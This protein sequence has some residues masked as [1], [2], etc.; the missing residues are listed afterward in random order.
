M[1]FE[2]LKSVIGTLEQQPSW[3]TRRQFY[4][5]VQ[6]WPKAVGHL[7]ARQTRPV[8][9]QRQV[10]YV[11]VS[12]A[13]WAQTLTFERQHILAQLNGRLSCPL[14]DLKFSAAQWRQSPAPGRRQP[15][16]EWLR[17]HPSYVRPTAP[18]QTEATKAEAAKAE[19][20]PTTP[21]RSKPLSR[22]PAPRPQ[23]SESPSLQP[24]SLQ[25]PSLQSP[26]SEPLTKTQQAF[27]KWSQQIRASHAHQVLCPDCHCHCPKGEIARWQK[28][29]LCA[30]K[31]WPIRQ[32]FG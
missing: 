19:P 6:Y 29:A 31:Q 9:I 2:P 17:Q 21:S 32:P 18:A 30:A 27:E 23:T 3:Q 20:S 25:S 12:T 8:S 22:T 28:C 4:Q 10:L 13:A 15:D 16:S 5:V 1:S 14:S 11:S 26:S 24:S 7:V